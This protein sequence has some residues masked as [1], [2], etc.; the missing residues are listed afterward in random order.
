MKGTLDIQFDG[1][2]ERIFGV[3]HFECSPEI[4]H[5]HTSRSCMKYCLYL[6]NK[7]MAMVWNFEVI[8]DKF[9]AGRINV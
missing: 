6:N 7:N 9:I 1:D 4:G 2:N 3:R 5:R 8:S